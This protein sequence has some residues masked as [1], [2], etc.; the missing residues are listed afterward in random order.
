MAIK[1][2]SAIALFSLILLANRQG[3]AAA[4]PAT[5][6]GGVVFV[7]GG[8]TGL[9][10]LFLSAKM[11]LPK[12]GVPHEFRE[13]DWTHGK[14]RPLRDLQD[15]RHFEARAGDLA[16][17]I[18]DQL[19][20]EPDRPVYLIGH[21]AGAGMV[22]LAAGMLPPESV[23]RIILLSPAVS[24][25]FDLR[26]ALKATRGEIVSF[27]SAFD[28]VVLDLGTSLFGTVDRRYESAAGLDGFEMPANLSAAD[29]EMYGRL[30]QVPWRVEKL[31]ELQGG[32][33]NSSVMP[34][35]LAKQVKPWLMK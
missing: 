15:Q 20:R 26:P 21:S 33:H 9:D 8:I 12:L 16:E 1:H 4:E 32:L 23:E 27:N 29:R 7:A 11:T 30:V 6:S 18:R 25:Q 5:P 14:M 22:L 10:P 28:R 2:A 13:F 24:P 3:A 34:I 17:L 35:F 31:L 19:H